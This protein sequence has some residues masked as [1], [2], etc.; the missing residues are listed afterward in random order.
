MSIADEIARGIEKQK[1]RESSLGFMGIFLLECAVVAFFAG[2]ML[3]S[4]IVGFIVFVVS[5]FTIRI[6]QLFIL[7]SAGFS[8]FWAGMLS[9]ILQAIQGVPD[10]SSFWLE[11]LIFPFTSMLSFTVGAIVFL[12]L[13]IFHMSLGRAVNQ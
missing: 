10:N 7:F 2:D 12:V 13:F 6:R 11:S 9:N 1:E 3:N 5:F 4:W 8:Y